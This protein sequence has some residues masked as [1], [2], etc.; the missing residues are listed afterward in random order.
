MQLG[1]GTYDLIL[2]TTYSGWRSAWAWGGQVL[3][4]LRNGEG[5]SGYTLGN[6]L[7]LNGWALR[8]LT[9]WLAASIRVE[10]QSWGNIQGADSELN[11]AM[12]PTADPDRRSG[13]RIDLILGLSCYLGQGQLQRQRFTLEVGSPL[14]ES[15]DG[16]QLGSDWQLNAGWQ[17]TF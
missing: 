5:P 12:V 13:E 7:R 14:Y 8:S 9:D 3:G 1:S 17:L 6:H 15:L 2:G 10:A 4:T 11:P 16:P